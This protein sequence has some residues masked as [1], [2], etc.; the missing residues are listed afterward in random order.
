MPT[1]LTAEEL[2]E[3]TVKDFNDAGIYIPHLSANDRRRCYAIADAIDSSCN[4]G[5]R[6]LFDKY[7]AEW[8]TLLLKGD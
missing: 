2:L 3:N 1:E 4:Y 5:N 6:E 8:R 7:L